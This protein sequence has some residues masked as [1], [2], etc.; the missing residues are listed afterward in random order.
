MGQQ[1]A[2][3]IGR[4]SQTT[5]PGD[6]SLEQL[7]AAIMEK[8]QDPE[9]H[10]IIV[11]LPLPEHLRP[12]QRQVL[13]LVSPA[14]DVDCF[15]PHNVGKLSLGEPGF[16][17]A[18]PAGILALLRHYNI[19]LQ[20]KHI[21]VLGK[22]DIVG[23]PLALMLAME[24]GPAAT[25]TMCDRFTENVW[26]ITRTANIV[27]VAAGKHHLLND[28]AALRPDGT[29]VVIDVG[30]HRIKSAE[31]KMVLQGDVDANAVRGYCQWLTP[32]PGGV[33]PMT[34]A[35]LL[36]QVVEAAS[37]V[38][39]CSNRPGR[40]LKGIIRSSLLEGQRFTK[41][42]LAALM[43]RLDPTFPTGQLASAVAT[44]G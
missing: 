27:V 21:V 40:A 19:P 41:A 43:V 11:Q 4:F 28:P 44:L 26:A 10:G 32:V 14:K 1:A 42:E 8:N 39:R 35:C 13:D 18:T 24:Q 6:V 23:R 20:G 16:R 5:L 9:V 31:G 25:V 7:S 2:N 29:C 37:R 30:I 33:G 34:V 17:P 22:S 15:H 36:E 12:H 3:R 38:S